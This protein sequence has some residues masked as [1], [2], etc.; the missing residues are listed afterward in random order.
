MNKIENYIKIM[1]DNKNYAVGKLKQGKKI[2]PTVLDWEIYKKVKKLDAIWQVS[3]NGF[4]TTKSKDTEIYLHDVVM[5][6]SNNKSDKPILHI[7]RIGIDNRISNLMYDTTNKIITKNM[8]KKDRIIDLT[9]SGIKDVNKL[10]SF[11]WYMKAN[12]THGERFM[13]SIG[14]IKWKSS[15]SKILSLRYKLE[16]TKKYL[17][18]LKLDRKDL[19]EKYSMNNDLNDEGHKLVKSFIEI[20]SKNDFNYVDHDNNK[21]DL[22]LKQDLKGLSRREKILLDEF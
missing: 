17:R 1:H 4:I 21:T 11:V 6:L 3:S 10:P 9:G 2:V 13:V 16:E 19:F 18:N 15:S 7:N 20:C 8:K 5:R 22:Y 14:D 12:D